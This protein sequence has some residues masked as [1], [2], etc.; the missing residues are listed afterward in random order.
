[1]IVVYSVVL[2]FYVRR[3]KHYTEYTNTRKNDMRYQRHPGNIY[4]QDFVHCPSCRD[5]CIKSNDQKKIE[6]CSPPLPS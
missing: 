4:N 5:N 2:V 6:L 3:N 1:M